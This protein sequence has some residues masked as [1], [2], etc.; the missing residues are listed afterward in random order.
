IGNHNSLMLPGDRPLFLIN[1]RGRLFQELTASSLIV[2]DLDGRVVRGEGEL[3]K[4]AFHI[5][6]RIHLRRPEAACVMHVHPQYLTALS[7]LEKP[8]LALAHHN[9]LL[10]N[11]RIVVDLAGDEPVGDH[12]EGDRI[13]DL[14][15]GKSIMVMAGHG[16]T[17][18]GPTVADAFDELYIAERTCMYQTTALSTGRPLRRLPDRLRRNHLGAWGDRMDARLHLDAWRR[19]L[20][21]DEPDYAT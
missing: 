6:A 20:D 11:D 13:A 5:H 12:D 10:L 8:E 9:N 16:V 4:V 19:V 1:P 3:R 7:L 18:V 14:M 15:G 2:C 17:V 21:R